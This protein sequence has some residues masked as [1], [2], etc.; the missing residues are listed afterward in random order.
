MYS[1]ACRGML[2]VCAVLTTSLQHVR[3]RYGLMQTKAYQGQEE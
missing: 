1:T 3:L 2:P